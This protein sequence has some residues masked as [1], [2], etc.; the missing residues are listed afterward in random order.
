MQQIL[1]RRF[2][3]RLKLMAALIL[4]G[5]SLIAVRTAPELGL[6][7]G[8]ALFEFL[9]HN[10][11]VAHDMRESFE[12][13]AGLTAFAIACVAVGWLWYRL[14]LSWRRMKASIAGKQCR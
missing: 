5:L 3:H 7:L 11:A 2:R 13:V 8:R 1:P 6:R 10:H 14:I 4:G 12:A 9:L